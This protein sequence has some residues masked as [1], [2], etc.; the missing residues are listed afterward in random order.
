MI[1]DKNLIPKHK[2]IFVGY[3]EQYGVKGYDSL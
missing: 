3:E 2:C 1:N